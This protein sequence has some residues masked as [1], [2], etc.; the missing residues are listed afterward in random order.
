MAGMSVSEAIEIIQGFRYRLNPEESKSFD[1]AIKELRREGWM[2]YRN[3]E[4][5][6]W[7]LEKYERPFKLTAD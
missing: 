6:A 4:F 2:S 1:W 5:L 3:Q 7:M